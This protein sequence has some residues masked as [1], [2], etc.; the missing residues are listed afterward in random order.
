MNDGRP[1]TPGASWVGLSGDKFP[2]KVQWLAEH[3]VASHEAGTKGTWARS[4]AGI[5]LG[6]PHQGFLL[7]RRMGTWI[8]RCSCRECSGDGSGPHLL[9]PLLPSPGQRAMQRLQQREPLTLI[10]L[11]AYW[12]RNSTA[13]ASPF[14][15]VSGST[16]LNRVGNRYLQNALSSLTGRSQCP[17]GMAEGL[18]GGGWSR[19]PTS[20]LC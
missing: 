19:S 20:H 3:R 1:L 6:L 16:A 18:E 4:R 10:F 12:L 13:V 7:W 2:L 15:R 5:R 9:P 8:Q 17:F 14:A 11:P